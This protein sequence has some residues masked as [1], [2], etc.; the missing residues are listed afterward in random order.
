MQRS[1]KF[2][3]QCYD[4]GEAGVVVLLEQKNIVM[5]Q[6]FWLHTMT[7]LSVKKAVIK[8]ASGIGRRVV[9]NP[10]FL[11]GTAYFGELGGP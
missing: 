1:T 11:L 2:K 9:L 5:G 7:S 6:K 8:N 10:S 4:L 3:R